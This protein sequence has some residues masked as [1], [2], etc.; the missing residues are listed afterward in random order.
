MDSIGLSWVTPHGHRVTLD[1]QLVKWIVD[2]AVTS[3]FNSN[4]A[5]FTTKQHL[6]LTS[7]A[8]TMLYTHKKTTAILSLEILEMGRRAW[9][10]C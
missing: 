5:L 10:L 9:H 1:N 4:D 7:N 3:S 2:N 6:N 8:T